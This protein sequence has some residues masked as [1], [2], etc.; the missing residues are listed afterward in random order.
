MIEPLDSL[1]VSYEQNGF[2]ADRCYIPRYHLSDVH[3]YDKNETARSLNIFDGKI[4]LNWAIVSAPRHPIIT[5]TIE[6]VVDVIKHEFINDPV[7][8]T[9]IMYLIHS[10]VHVYI[11]H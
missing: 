4:L 10:F 1:I 9:A 2:N 11:V 5:R 8:T 7:R 6:N 3:C